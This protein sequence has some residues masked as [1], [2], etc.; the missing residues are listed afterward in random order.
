MQREASVLKAPTL[1]AC[2]LATAH[3]KMKY[4][5][6]NIDVAE[7]ALKCTLKSTTKSPQGA[8]SAQSAG[9]FD[10]QGGRDLL[11]EK[12]KYMW[13]LDHI[14]PLLNTFGLIDLD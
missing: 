10:G 7:L 13:P 11:S 14:F 8:F 3:W 12:C 2:T 1:M 6:Q 9:R 5:M 4:M